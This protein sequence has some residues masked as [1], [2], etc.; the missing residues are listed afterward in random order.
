MGSRRKLCYW[1]DAAAHIPQV[2]PADVEL[3]PLSLRL[4]ADCRE[5]HKAFDLQLSLHSEVRPGDGQGSLR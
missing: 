3:T 1:L 5:K 2:T 4:R